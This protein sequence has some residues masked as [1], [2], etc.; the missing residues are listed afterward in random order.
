MAACSG[1]I[2]SQWWFARSR[3]KPFWQVMDFVAPCV[4]LGAGRGPRGQLHQRR[5]VGPRRPTRRCPGPWCSRRAARMLPRHPSQVYQFL[6]EGLLLFIVLWLYARKERKQAQ[7]S[8][9]F[10]IGY[11][12]AALH[13]R[14]LPRAR[15]PPGPAVAGHEHGPVAVH[16]HDP[17]R[18]AALG[19]GRAAPAPQ[20]GSA[21]GSFHTRGATRA[22]AMFSVIIMRNY[23]KLRDAPG[24]QLPAR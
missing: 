14:V 7:V 2:A 1:V 20:R 18:R 8:A 5:T 9:V 10:L 15:Q 13:R 16:A 17:G 6:L 3:G 11:G 23:R 12:A 4:P 21:L 22:H 24:P 19:L